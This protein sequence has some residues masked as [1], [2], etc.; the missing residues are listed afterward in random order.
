MEIIKELNKSKVNIVMIAGRGSGG[1]LFPY[2]GT[3]SA[4]RMRYLALGLKE[5]GIN[6]FVMNL[7][8]GF[9]IKD[10]ENKEWRGNYQGIDYEFMPRTTILNT[11]YIGRKWQ[12]IMGFTR[13]LI[14]LIKMHIYGNIDCVYLYTINSVK[15]SVPVIVLCRIMKIPV[16]IELCEWYPAF[17][18]YSFWKRKIFQKF[19]LRKAQ[20]IIAISEFLVQKIKESNYISKIDIPYLKIPILADI[21]Q[22]TIDINYKKGEKGYFLWCGSIQ[23]YKETVELLIQIFS[24]VWSIENDV[25]LI[26]VGDISDNLISSFRI[27]QSKY[28]LPFYSIEFTGFLSEKELANY[29]INALALLAPL[30]NNMRD[31]AR[32]PTK[33]GEY[34]SSGRPIII[35]SFCEFANYASDGINAIYVHEDD[36]NSYASALKK[37]ID[38]PKYAD[39]VGEGGRELCKKEFDYH[40]HGKSLALFINDIIIYN[41]K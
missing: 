13:G 34:L 35:P 23:G 32:F 27:F 29:Y 22:W 39:L 38:S 31:L 20:A 37:V 41:K 14:R 7:V 8:S 3:A 30:R 15:V 12:D 21:D 18:D 26:I 4:M 16:V 33:I 1:G 25:K 11:S 40:I 19:T 17:Q 28:N 36:I 24:K 10:N 5:N 2:G 6:V 9:K